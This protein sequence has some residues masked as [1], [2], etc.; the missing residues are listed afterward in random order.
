MRRTCKTNRPLK[1]NLAKN[2]MSDINVDPY[3]LH[4]YI[5]TEKTTSK[6]HIVS[7]MSKACVRLC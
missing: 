2:G 7:Q 1:K 6:K 4:L 3:W 5:E